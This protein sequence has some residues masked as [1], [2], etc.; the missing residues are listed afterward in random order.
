LAGAP[1]SAVTFSCG[2]CGASLAF[3]GVRTQ[4]CPYCASPNFV[5]KPPSAGQPNPTFLVAFT[6]DAEVA[7]RKLDAAGSMVAQ[8]DAAAGTS[9]DRDPTFET[10][11]Q[12]TLA[13]RFADPARRT[14]DPRSG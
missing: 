8:S 9:D 13:V 10:R 7:R 2:H 14:T 11:H 6:G 4:T 12:T 5:E 3:E 1:V